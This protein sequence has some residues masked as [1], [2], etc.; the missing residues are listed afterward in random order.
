MKVNEDIAELMGIILGDGNIYVDESNGHYQLRITGHL[1]NDKDYHEKFIK[2]LFWRIF[3]KELKVKCYENRRVLY[4][5]GKEIICEL[6][7]LGLV[8]GNKLKNNIN[9]P[10]WIFSNKE[11]MKS[12]LRGLIDTD[13][14]VFPKSTIKIS[15]K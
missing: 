10:T 12:C 5:Y 9:I 11:Y 14:S 13:G 8:S 4:Y 1:S 2:D 15:F 7:K 3:K 6:L